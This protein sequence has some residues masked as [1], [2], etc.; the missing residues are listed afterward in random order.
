MF[1]PRSLAAAS[2]IFPKICLPAKHLTCSW[3]GSKLTPAHVRTRL[4]APVWWSWPRGPQPA[5]LVAFRVDFPSQPCSES[6][7]PFGRPAVLKPS[8]GGGL[9][10]FL[11]SVSEI[12]PPSPT[13]PQL[14]VSV[15]RVACKVVSFT[16]HYTQPE[17]VPGAQPAGKWPDT[18]QE[19]CT[20]PLAS[21]KWAVPAADPGCGQG[22]R[23]SAL[24]QGGCGR[25][26][27]VLL[28]GPWETCLPPRGTEPCPSRAATESEYEERDW[29]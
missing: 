11:R 25:G 9:Q 16:R 27:P 1:L 2:L 22:H 18:T 24:P 20:D 13:T 29:T 5:F 6:S 28:N 23:K 4:G 26:R 14:G 10:H 12:S 21:E 7:H 17:R 19:R 3:S 15:C 8:F